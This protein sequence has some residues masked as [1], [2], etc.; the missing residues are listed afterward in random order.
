MPIIGVRNASFS[1]SK[2]IYGCSSISLPKWINGCTFFFFWSV[3]HCNRKSCQW[4]VDLLMI[5]VYIKHS[6]SFGEDINMTD[7]K[8]K[9]YVI[10]DEKLNH[11][12][13]T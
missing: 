3:N 4:T 10:L 2:V 9:F 13:S 5:F 8:V 1:S 11:V 7:P 6:R 12:T